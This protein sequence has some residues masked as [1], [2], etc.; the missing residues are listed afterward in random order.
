MNCEEYVLSILY[1]RCPAAMHSCFSASP[2]GFLSILY[3][4]C[5]SQ[6]LDTIKLYMLYHLSILYLRCRGFWLFVFVDF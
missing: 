5:M 4:R 2:H 6:V 3:L 1:L